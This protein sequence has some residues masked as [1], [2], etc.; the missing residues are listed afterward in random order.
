MQAAH[1]GALQALLQACV[2]RLFGRAVLRCIAHVLLEHGTASPALA[3]LWRT[4]TLSAV[5]LA[6]PEGPRGQP[7]TWCSQPRMPPACARSRR[8]KHCSAA[9]LCEHALLQVSA[10][11]A[12]LQV[13]AGHALLQVSA[14]HALL[15]VCK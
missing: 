11:H 13:C 3:D 6:L 10:G 9:P 4:P 14:G 12:L 5:L 1:A 7:G 8:R 15:Q 2:P